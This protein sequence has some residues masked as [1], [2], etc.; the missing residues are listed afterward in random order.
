MRCISGHPGRRPPTLQERHVSSDTPFA[1]P[2]ASQVVA[3]LLASPLFAVRELNLPVREPR[4]IV[5]EDAGARDGA[6]RAP[7]Q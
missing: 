1:T 7:S 2:A 4:C 5:N 3:G 6:A